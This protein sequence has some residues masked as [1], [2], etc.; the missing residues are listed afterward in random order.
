MSTGITLAIVGGGVAGCSAAYFA[1]QAFPDAKIVLFEKSRRTGG[2]LHTVDFA[3]VRLELGAGFLHS[4]NQALI[5]LTDRLGV[6]RKTIERLGAGIW[7]GRGLVATIPAGFMGARLALARRYGLPPLLHMRR[8]VRETLRRWVSVYRLPTRQTAFANP[9]DLLQRLDLFARAQ[10][11]S[12]DL[13]TSHRVTGP[14]LDELFSGISR[15]IFDQGLAINGFAGTIA[16]IAAGFA[17]GHAWLLEDGNERLCTA[18][19]RVSA[20][21]VRLNSPV[22]ALRS[23][24]PRGGKTTEVLIRGEQ[25][26]NFDAVILATPIEVAG[27]DLRHAG[28]ASVEPREW[29]PVHVTCVAG[30]LSPEHFSA[31]VRSELPPTILTT[32][33]VSFSSLRRVGFTP[34]GR[35]VYK[36]QS[37][38]AVDD[39]VLRALFSEV[40]DVRRHVWPAYPVL[41]PTIRWPAFRL[42]EGLYYVNAMESAVSTLETEVVASQNVVRLMREDHGSQ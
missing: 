26:E 33:R 35:A 19:L 4:S 17:A 11:T 41:T 34:A 38:S 9:A 18:L 6:R 42:R 12:F 10:E 2:R 27:M 1:R 21:D 20:V 29:H 22:I 7:D 24:E 25:S 13:L 16:F 32:E 28:A 5:A 30:R 3:E 14:I 39:G 37:S 40:T 8:L 15:A 31:R 36:I 23:L